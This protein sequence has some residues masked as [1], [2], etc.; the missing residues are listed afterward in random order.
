MRILQV[1]PHLS[2]GGAERVVIELSN[3]L[4]DKDHDVTLLLASQVNPILNQQ[5]LS[6]GVL[7]KVV[8]SRTQNRFLPYILLPIWVFKH[9]KL[10]R[11]YDVVHC[12]LT[13]GLVFGFI[14][15]VFRKFENLT[16]V[17]LIA[18]C[19]VVGISIT[20]APRFINEKLS[21]FFDAFVLMAMDNQWRRFIARKKIVNIQ[22]VA[23]GI[24]P[25]S[26]P[27]SS[28]NLA[29]IKKQKCEQITHKNV[30]TIGTISRL[31]SERKPWL[32]LEVFAEVQKSMDLEVNFILGGEGPERG[33]LLKIAEQLELSKNLT[34][35]GLVQDPR[36]VL[37]TL[38]LYIT[39]NV[40]EI[41]GIAGLEAIF[42]GIPV[43]GIQ[44]AQDYESGQE[45][46]IW[47]DQNPQIVGRE[48]ATYLKSPKQL[49]AI[50]TS[51]FSLADKKYSLTRMLEDYLA[52]YR[53]Q[54]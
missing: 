24:S 10:L 26:A 36:A 8:S 39:L 32:F 1:L 34:M 44:L 46:W 17:R 49:Q 18:T 33:S 13:Y 12:H 53:P 45:D 40:E 29:S 22:V 19:H 16:N 21:V 11:T 6:E 38:D 31:Q 37:A 4:I 27:N 25:L 28:S 5:Y 47:S 20:R 30:L 23:N 54:K 50:A 2:K 43:V 9:R 3:A 42:A 35:L 15:S 51:Q 52:L 41:T 14:F 7:V 48:I